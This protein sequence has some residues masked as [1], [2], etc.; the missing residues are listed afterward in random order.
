L[1]KEG[2]VFVL[3][4]DPAVEPLREVALV[5]GKS[6][7][8]DA[9]VTDAFHELVVYDRAHDQLITGTANAGQGAL[10]A[11]AYDAA[12]KTLN[13]TQFLAEA[14]TDCRDLII[15]PDGQH[16]LY[17]CASGNVG[18]T[19]GGFEGVADFGTVD[20]TPQGSW[21]M[22]IVSKDPRGAAFTPDGKRVIFAG[23]EGR[24]DVLRLA[25]YK[26]PSPGGFTSSEWVRRGVRVAPFPTV[27][28]HWP[29]YF[30]DAKAVGAPQNQTV[31][32]S[33]TT[34]DW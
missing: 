18:P 10:R 13:Q 20:F 5:D 29:V 9:I 3:M 16:L 19:L 27:N 33:T 34:A 14:G 32:T 1:G 25:S 30:I 12:A 28:G 11:Y 26:L 23:G 15:S 4:E 7:T 21:G 31:M 22:D 8:V 6:A 24:Y 17:L 2:R